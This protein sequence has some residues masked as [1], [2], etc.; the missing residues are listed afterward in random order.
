MRTMAAQPLPVEILFG[1]YLGILAG[2]VPALIAGALG[3]LFKYFTDVSIPGFGVIALALAIAGVNGGLLALADETITGAEHN[4]ALVVAII[5]VLMLTL[6][7][8]AQGD[9]LGGTLP[10]RLTIKRLADR[11]LSTDVVELVGGRGQV[12]ITV[13]GD[14]GD[15][16]GY[17][18]L[19]PEL[20]AEIRDGEWTF[21]ADVPLAELET[22][23]ADRLRTD[24]DL[25]DIV[26]RLDE[27][28]RATINA[29]P[30][31]GGLSRRVPAGKRAVSAETL[32][33]PGLARGDEVRI[34]T[35]AGS[36]EGTVVGVKPLE[37]PADSTDVAT[38]SGDADA[39]RADA[40]RVGRGDANRANAPSPAV[41]AGGRGRVTLS[42]ARTRAEDVL[43]AD[44]PRLVVTARGRRREYELT[45]LLRRAGKRFKRVRVR[46]DGPLD[47]RTIA[48]AAIRDAY[49]V[50]VFALR[51]DRWQFVPSGDAE[52]RA[53]DELFV[54]GSRA[55]LDRFAEVTA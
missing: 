47:G 42:V 21:P 5:V 53:D 48:E 19:S 28:A 50:A 44:A 55:A 52:L 20:R 36:V 49:G 14:V 41:A 11:T 45:S 12:R 10:R 43:A 24:H 34:A 38:D 18:P 25:A 26:V 51:R 46:P 17:P 37:G 13:A 27:R 40:D 1:I 15:V 31:V 3:F 30:P 8:H 4:V 9:R 16:E 39:D 6:Y 32:V 7:A 22:R 54:V 35:E 2:V 23:L 33:P 29:A